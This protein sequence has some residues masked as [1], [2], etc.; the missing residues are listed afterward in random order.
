[1]IG[2]VQKSTRFTNQLPT[3]YKLLSIINQNS[4]QKFKIITFAIKDV[5]LNGTFIY[6]ININLTKKIP[7]YEDKIGNHENHENQDTENHSA[8]TNPYQTPQTIIE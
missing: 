2:N 5:T 3:L 8:H 1:M 7:V 4:F 6:V